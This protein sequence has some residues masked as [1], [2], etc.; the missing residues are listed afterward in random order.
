VIPAEA[1]RGVLAVYA[2]VIVYLA[3][4]IT[5]PPAAVW[6]YRKIRDR[7]GDRAQGAGIARRVSER[8]AETE[9]LEQLYA[10]DS[11]GEPS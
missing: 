8:A 11:A 5:L 10:M 6:L 4:V 7:R 2:I 1:S 9:L 3:A